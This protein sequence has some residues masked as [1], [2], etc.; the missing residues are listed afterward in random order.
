MQLSFQDGKKN[1]QQNLESKTQSNKSKSSSMGP[2]Q[3]RN[4]KYLTS[5]QT[6]IVHDVG[7]A[8]AMAQERKDKGK[9]F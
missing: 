6:Y 7:D 2:P 4:N 8:F 3:S 1:I 9:E 5:N